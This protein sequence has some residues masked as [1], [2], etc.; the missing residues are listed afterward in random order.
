MQRCTVCGHIILP[1]LNPERCPMCGAPRTKFEPFTG[2][3]GLS[4]SKTEENLKAALA[5]E[6]QANRRYLAFAQE[7]RAAGLDEAAEAFEAAASDETM[8]A[9][10]HL[11]YLGMIQ[12][13]E[14]NLKA[15][16]EGESYER[17]T[18]YPGFEKVAAEEGFPQ[19]AQYFQALAREENKH[20]N[21]Y[22]KILEVK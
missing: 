9:H 1:G 17:D 14:S 5:G 22:E 18:M 16:I 19:V 4:G 13:S 11:A 20:A 12:D 10:S 21:R 15:A 2:I 8:H 7:A 6:S 3:P